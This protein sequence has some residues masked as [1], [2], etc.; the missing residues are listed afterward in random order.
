[1]LLD[2]LNINNTSN[3]NSSI[4][5]RSL[6][7]QKLEI[8]FQER[9]SHA[10]ASRINGS[11]ILV[12][13]ES[14]DGLVGY[15]EGCPR[16]YVTGETLDTAL[17]FFDAVAM[18][19][20]ACRNLGHLCDWIDSHS[21]D[22]DKNPAAWCAIECAVIDLMRR[23]SGQ[24]IEGLLGLPRLQGDYH[25]TAL[26]GTGSIDQFSAQLKRY[27]QVGFVDYKIKLSGELSEDRS[28]VALVSQQ[29]AHIRIRLDA[30]NLWRD[31]DDAA[32]YIEELGGAIFAIE[33]ALTARDYLAQRELSTRCNIAIVLDESFCR[34][35]DFDHIDTGNIGDAPKNDRATRSPWII[36]IRVSKMGGIVRSL[37]I[38]QEAKRRKI[39]LIVGAQVGETSLLTRAALTIATVARGSLIAQEG[40]FGT[41]LLEYD[42]CESP[43]MF[44]IGGRLSATNIAT[45]KV[46]LPK[47]FASL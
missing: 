20:R 39:P 36:N 30:N 32:H 8:P 46:R 24:T 17:E 45:C 42:I 31:A 16:S 40:A 12:R 47:V 37:K 7:A 35:S 26:L 34:L 2:T 22:V 3:R 27:Q 44:G 15:G 38:I 41:H 6:S 23:S 10:S 43:I 29:G 19:V 33:E 11:S 25:Y 18:D 9:F 5:I 4:N 1:M 28:R 13:I 21:E 14:S